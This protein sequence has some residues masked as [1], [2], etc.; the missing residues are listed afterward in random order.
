MKIAFLADTLETMRA[1]EIALCLDEVGGAARLAVAIE[2][3]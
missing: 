2:I 3:V 1:E